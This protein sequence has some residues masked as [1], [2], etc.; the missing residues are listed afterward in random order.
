M[1][2]LFPPRLRPTGRAMASRG[3]TASLVSAAAQE[4]MKTET[5]GRERPLSKQLQQMPERPWPVSLFATGNGR[6]PRPAV[7]LHFSSKDSA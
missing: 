2:S 1:N 3:N 4:E 7:P 5:E 6:G